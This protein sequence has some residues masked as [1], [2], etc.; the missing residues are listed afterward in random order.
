M[1]AY[2]TQQFIAVAYT[3]ATVTA[4]TTAVALE[5]IRSLTTVATGAAQNQTIIIASSN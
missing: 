4:R 3:P 5:V 2:V 1:A